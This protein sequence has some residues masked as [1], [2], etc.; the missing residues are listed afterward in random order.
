VTHTYPK[1]P[2]FGEV[3]AELR[4]AFTRKRER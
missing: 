2:R 3:I 1:Q 4:P